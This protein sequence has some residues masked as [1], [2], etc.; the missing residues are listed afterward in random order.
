MT[1]HTPS[2][3]GQHVDGIPGAELEET[4]RPKQLLDLPVEILNAILK[5]LNHTN[6]LTSLA[7][8]H[9]TLHTLAI[10]YIYGRF[11]IVWPDNASSPEPRAGV[12]ALTYGLSTLVMAEEVFGGRRGQSIKQNIRR[13]RGNHFASFTKKFSLGNGPPEWVQDYLITKESGKMLNT[14]VALA[15][16]RM[17]NLES[18]V[19]DMPTGVLSA[20]WDSLSSLGDHVDNKPCRLERI[21]VRW[22]D[23][24]VEPRN[25]PVHIPRRE[26][27]ATPPLIALQHVENPSFSILPPLK[28]ISVLDID[29]VQY[30]DELSLLIQRSVDKLRELRI[31]IASLAKHRDFAN[32]WEGDNVQQVDRVNPVMSCITIG[33]KRLGGVLGILTGMIFDLRS[34]EPQTTRP[35]RL[36]RRSNATIGTPQVVGV[37]GGISTIPATEAAVDPNV[38]LDPTLETIS[39][40]L[41]DDNT[42][43]QATPSVEYIQA[44]PK[45][46][47]PATTTSPSQLST[48]SGPPEIT[49]PHRA[50]GVPIAQDKQS[51]GQNDDHTLAPSRK[52]SLD[53]L[54][55][56]DVPLSIPILLNAIDWSV[57][58]TLTLLSCPN[59]EHL[60]KALRRQYSSKPSQSKQ[61][62]VSGLVDPS[63]Q[64]AYNGS[65]S[66]TMFRLNLKHIY[67][68][69][70]STHLIS[71]IKDTLEPNS[72]ESV[73]FL[74]GSSTSSNVSL[75]TI[76]NGVLRRHRTS[77]RKILIDSGE[78][79]AENLPGANAIWRQWMFNRE[80]IKFLGK[81][82]C[83]K[84]LGAALDY[85]DWH[86]FLQHLP[87][88]L[89]L[90]SLYI[91]FIVNLNQG[92]PVDTREIALQIVDIVA[93]RPELEICYLG[94]MKKCFEV[95]EQQPGTGKP[96]NHDRTSIDDD[97]GSE[98]AE[99]EDEDSADEDD[100]D[101]D[102]DD[103]DDSEDT[104]S[105]TTDTY[106]DSELGVY[107]DDK[108]L[109]A[110]R[111]REILYYDDKVSVFRARHGRL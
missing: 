70:V 65:S 37:P 52:L 107:E 6:D 27:D 19:W 87:S 104:A 91:P 96:T 54:E 100:D 9:S 94:I 71:F 29:E 48:T 35:T 15:V 33:E 26:G 30:L 2:L 61:K 1:N 103:D 59:H 14:L 106:E 44:L 41:S 64:A 102:N 5:E 12:D 58:T 75:D 21:A 39:G 3:L 28:S 45:T 82:P 31:G 43:V 60:W 62:Y 40:T 95:L 80:I 10:P 46:F 76:F 77:L 57:L 99:D 92:G 101:E 11:D 88:L 25:A 42:D 24:F 32:V 68:D 84:E 79:D 85:R 17:R 50:K 111:L 36:R 13:R 22:H 16:A 78:K 66:D 89:K 56:E 108:E 7:L 34:V 49:V 97:S 109:P 98:E 63:L 110:L 53:A 55:L 72:L 83:L 86:F 69:T 47:L 90:R 18:F 8:C 23:N 20:V 4:I 81:M 67:T 51:P 105:D 93:L 73:F 74:Q 38:D